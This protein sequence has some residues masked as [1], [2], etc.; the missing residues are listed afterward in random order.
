MIDIHHHCL[1]DVDDGP[2]EWDEAVEMCRIAAD[3]GID[4]IIATPHVLRERWRTP[5]RDELESRIATL[6]EKTNDRP[7]LLLG[8]EY[9]F[10]HDMAEVLRAGRPIV[11]LADSRYVLVELAANSVPPL[12]EQP[13]YRIQL[14]GW[15]PILA[16]PERNS[17]LQA[18]TELLAELIEHGVRMQITAGSLTGEFGPRARAV[19]ET[20]L[21]HGLVHFMATDAHNTSRRPPRARQAIKRLRELAGDDVCDALTVRNPRAVIE[22]RPLDF[23]PEPSVP[24]TGG[25]L[26]RLKGFFG[27][28]RPTIS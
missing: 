12:I 7:R 20:W 3:E 28:K 19:S 15:T 17:M 18:H 21:R 5:E 13:L 2:R 25:L 4:T 14:D 23:E 9:F 11:P 6:R 24:E 16:H 1:P 22:N 26:T 27:R 10:A 8:S